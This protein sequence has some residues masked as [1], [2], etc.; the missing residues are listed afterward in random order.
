MKLPEGFGAR[1]SFGGDR[2]H[3]VVEQ[4]D[5]QSQTF[6]VAQNGERRRRREALHRLPAREHRKESRQGAVLERNQGRQQLRTG[7]GMRELVEQIVQVI[8]A[9]GVERRA[10]VEFAGLQFV[11]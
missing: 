6:R 4:T 3:R 11:G 10:Q 1:G 8:L 5:C 7:F 2:L 9:G